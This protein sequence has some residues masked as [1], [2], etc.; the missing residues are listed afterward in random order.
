MTERETPRLPTAAAAEYLTDAWQR[1]ILTLDVM[2]RRAAQYE[3]HAAEAAP[4][5]LDYRAELVMDGRTLAR[6]V[7]YL[8][9]RIVPPEGVAIDPLRRLDRH[10]LDTAGIINDRMTA[11]DP[12]FELDPVTPRPV[13]H[14]ALAERLRMKRTHVSRS[15]R[16]LVHCGY[17]ARGVDD[18]PLATYR[19]C[20]QR[21]GPGLV[22]SR[23]VTP[24]P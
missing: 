12:P 24:L 18:G 7:N 6:P 15:L 17:L 10:I 13:K 4:N 22:P 19:L 20:Y 2:R 5:V 23:E 8:L 11:Y 1:T 3:A 16:H 21:S 14:I 9:T